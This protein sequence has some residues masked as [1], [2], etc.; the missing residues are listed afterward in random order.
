M[1][2]IGAQVLGKKWAK[3]RRNFKKDALVASLTE[4]FSADRPSWITKAQ[5]TKALAWSPPGFAPPPAPS[6]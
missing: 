2:D 1:L 6:H 5:H 4:A 3:T